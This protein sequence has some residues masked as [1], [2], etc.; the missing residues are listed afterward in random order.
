M[1]TSSFSQNVNY[2]MCFSQYED[3]V[4]NFVS[5]QGLHFVRDDAIVE[6]IR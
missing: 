4:M 1:A 5:L 3:F 6:H 2:V